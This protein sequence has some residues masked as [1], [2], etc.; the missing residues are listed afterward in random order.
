MSFNVSAFPQS[1]NAYD[2]LTEAY[3]AVG[4][5]ELSDKN[6]AISKKLNSPLY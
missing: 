5:K 2:S 1:A 3:L 6:Y 4:N